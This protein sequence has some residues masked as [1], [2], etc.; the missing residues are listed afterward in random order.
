MSSKQAKQD[1]QPKA[2]YGE[3]LQ[4]VKPYRWVLLL[5]FIGAIVDASM[6]AGFAAMLSP[7]LD[8]GFVEQD[9]E[10]IRM[11]PFLIVGMFLIRAFGNFIAAY[12]FTWSGRKVVNDLRRQVFARYLKL[13]QKFYDQHASGGLISRMTFDIEQIDTGVTKNLIQILRESLAIIM[14]LGVMFYFSAKLAMIAFVVFP[15]V[16]VVIRV[17]NKRFRRIG[18]GIQ[19]SIA[20]ITQNVE[21]VVKGQKIVKIFKG[22]ADETQRFNKNIKNNR[23]LQVKI[24]ATKE[25][26]SSTVHLMIAIALAIIIYFAAQS[27]MSAGNFMSF[28]T[29]MLALMPSLKRMTQVFA[30]IQTTLAAAD[31]VMFILKEPIEADHGEHVLSQSPMTV[32]FQNISFAYEFDEQK[33]PLWA[34]KDFS[35]HMPAGQV[36][37]LVGASG[38]GKSTLANLLPRFYDITQGQITVNG[39]NINDVTLDSLRSQMAIVSQ[40]VVLFNDTVRNNI[41]YGSN[42]LKSEAEILEAAQK[43]NALSFIQE[44]PD[45]FDTILGDNG[46][47]LSGGQ[48]QRI[49]I[50]RAILKDAPILIL[51]EATS[52]LD[53]E[54]EQHIQ[55]ALNHVMTNKTTLVIAHRL[56]TIESAD[57]VVVMH[58]GQI[59]EQGSHNELMAK[60]G[61]YAQLQ[62]AQALTH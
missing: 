58:H 15:L 49:A 46:T 21:E 40:E 42:Q 18:H 44:L 34:I 59:A 45:G 22:D 16:A 14:Y 36:I 43:A 25:V 1:S 11:I 2:T 62:Q 61:L 19:G 35:L 38:S 17:I 56:S 10:W 5:A 55:Q 48:R 4:Y 8:N 20:R 28:M 47:R 23:Q 53:T 57:T 9:P 6:Q 3:L 60:Q 39:H 7:I 26:T 50:A 51:D 12:G 29:A 33:Q 27:N 31:S 13:P 37:A 32:D 41:A 52:A 30:A 54:S 24:V